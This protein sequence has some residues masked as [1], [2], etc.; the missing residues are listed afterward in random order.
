MNEKNRESVVNG[1][2]EEI[3]HLF[4]RAG[5]LKA[6][7]AAGAGVSALGAGAFAAPR[8]ASAQKA[9]RGVPASVMRGVYEKVKTPFKYGVVVPTPPGS[10]NVD[11]PSVFRFEESWYMLYVTFRE[12]AAG[13]ETFLAKS[14]DLLE[15]TTIGNVLPFREGAW[16]RVQ[17]AGYVSLQDTELGGSNA[18]GQHDGKYWLSYIGGGDPGYEAG[19]LSIGVANTTTPDEPAPWNRYDE[20]VL[21]PTD[22]DARGFETSKLFKSNVIRDPQRR[23][24]AEF[25]MFYNATYD[26][27]FNH[28]AIGIA[29][30]DDM[31]TWK[32]YGDGPVVTPY[33]D[34]GLGVIG[35]PQVVRMGDLWVMFHWSAIEFAPNGIFDSFACSYDL[36]NWTKWEGQ[37]LV[38]STEPYEY[39][40]AHKPWV[41]EHEGVVYHYY[42]AIDQQGRWSI[43]LATSKDLRGTSVGPLGI[44]ASASHTFAYDSPTDAVDSIVSYEGEPENRWTAFNSP[45]RTDWLQFTFPARRN[46]SGLVLHIYDDG[47]GVQAPRSYNVRYLDRDG[48]WRKAAGQ[49]RRPK[50]P[51]GSRPNTVRFGRVSTRSVRVYFEHKDGG[52][53]TEGIG[54]YSGVTEVEFIR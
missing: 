10:G 47:G 26:P 53:L 28:E 27:E 44:R 12:A 18:L 43:A 8:R 29:V 54:V 33:S 35:D 17:A 38:S 14:P 15:W 45:N 48:R 24:G 34:A 20:P 9:P 2:S 4:S 52:Y 49:T 41:I 37:A 25:V 21:R 3:R 11:S 50:T 6:A 40:E 1:G 23:L 36:L 32:R 31:Q 19:E 7:A 46:L 13:Y 5:F 39:N 16:D 22:P 51:V 42:S 30:S